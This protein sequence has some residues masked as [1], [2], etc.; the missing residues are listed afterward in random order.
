MG[1]D[2]VRKPCSPRGFE[3]NFG[4]SC[5]ARNDPSTEGA[6]FTSAPLNPLLMCL[7]WRSAE[8]AEVHPALFILNYFLLVL[9]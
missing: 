9:C 7:K 1:D 6:E 8:E 4:P 5:S 3:N 2:N